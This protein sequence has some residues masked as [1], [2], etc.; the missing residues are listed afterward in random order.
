MIDSYLIQFTLVPK[1]SGHGFK[2]TTEYNGTVDATYGG[3]PCMRWDV[4][5][6][7]NQGQWLD[8]SYFPGESMSESENYCRG[9]IGY[10]KPWCYYYYLASSDT[11]YWAYCPVPEEEGW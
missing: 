1:T 8:N 5:A 7:Y 4:A 9:L 2:K 11:L 6:Q 3:N 10:E